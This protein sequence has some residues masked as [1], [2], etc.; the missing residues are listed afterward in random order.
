MLYIMFIESNRNKTDKHSFHLSSKEMCV[1]SATYP[2]LELMT[3]YEHKAINTH[4]ECILY[5]LIFIRCHFQMIYSLQ[6]FI[7]TFKYRCYHIFTTDPCFNDNL[8]EWLKLIF[9]ILALIQ[10][11]MDWKYSSINGMILTTKAQNLVADYLCFSH[12]A[13]LRNPHIARDYR[14]YSIAV[15]PDLP[16]HCRRNHTSI[17]VVSGRESSFT[18]RRKDTLLTTSI[19]LLAV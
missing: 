15:P 17:D 1:F 18:L 16:A 6:I 12:R 13:E 10:E 2:N 9:T 5:W 7:N 8:T 14:K 11:Q 3:H 19:Q 4:L